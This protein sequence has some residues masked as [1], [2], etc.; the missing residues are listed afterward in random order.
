MNRE[1]A[2]K[3]IAKLRAEIERY[4]YLYHV[5]DRSV[6][7][8]AV[9]DSLKHELVALETQFPEFA[10]PDSPSQRIGGKPLA[11]FTKVPHEVTQW[12]LNDAFSETEAQ[13]F[14]ARV[15][16]LLDIGPND[17][18]DYSVELKIDGLHLVLT[19]KDGLFVRGA[20]RGD[21]K[22]G[23]D[24]TN[25]LKT[26]Q[27]LPLRL[28]EPID[29]IVEGEAY[30]KKSVFNDLNRARKKAGEEL[31]ANP[32]NATAGG[33][34]QLDPKIAASRRL[35]AFCY[36]ISQTNEE[37]LTQIDELKRLKALGFKVNT[38][39]TLC[40][41]IEEVVALWQ[42][43][44]KLR[45]KEDYWIDGM[46]VKVN[47]R[48][49][50]EQLGFTGKAPRWALALKFAPEEAT[51]VIEDIRVQVGRTG[52]LTPV[53][54]LRPVLVAGSTV[55]HAT[56]HNED[57]IK[58]LGVK[59]GDTVVIRKA[60]DI[61]PEVVTVLPNLR[62]GKEKNF[63]MP[64]Y[65][66]ICHSAVE[67]KAGGPGKTVA[68][69]CT[70]KRCYAQ[71]LRANVH[72]ASKQGID[73]VGCGEKVVEQLMKAGLVVDQADFF[74]VTV[75][76]LLALDRF[77]PVSAKKL[78]TSIAER[79]QISLNRFLNALGIRHV[80]EET[81][82]AL[83]ERFGNLQK[84]ADAS[85]EKLKAVSDIGSIVA[86]SI[87]E[88]FREPSNQKLL[89]KFLANG[90]TVVPYKQ[91]R[92]LSLSGKT[93]VLTGT[94]EHIDRSQAK[95]R[96]RALGGKTSEAVSKTTDYLVAGDNP[97][98]KLKKAE[99][100]TVTILDESSFLEIIGR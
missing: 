95:E 50:Q 88:W 27:S 100:L 54:H 83:A 24:V 16:K 86:R 53:A 74:T 62:T 21:G 38:R 57:Q 43:W 7:S 36:D 87:A 25:N 1:E 69:Y 2:K 84:I 22:I 75:D 35:D 82:L 29:L 85:E 37:L 9:N 19:Y 92:S 66:P 41:S 64:K 60:G 76:D 11:K 90:V 55:S 32:R 31:F 17:A 98:S 91:V 93:F 49:W 39:Y 14:D 65:C 70:N 97:G 13:Q 96:I 28:R 71:N 26:I 3:R 61:I 59:I 20:T 79:R 68:L 81:A 58:R 56:L 89:Q 77:A 73:I 45:I 67:K 94:L 30:M 80:G 44:E 6:V 23:E 78:V 99:E 48:D 52:V 42:R 10:T 18:I 40:H 63:S 51:T 46:V 8:D 33:I 12:S 47:R 4:R 15:R 72:F 34:R 5:E